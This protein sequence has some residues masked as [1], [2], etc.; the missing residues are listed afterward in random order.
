MY[1]IFFFFLVKLKS[2]IFTLFSEFISEFEN[3][4][5]FVN[6]IK[7][8]M[9]FVFVNCCQNWHPDRLVVCIL[10]K[11]AFS[12]DFLKNFCEFMDTLFMQKFKCMIK[13][14]STKNFIFLKNQ[15][16]YYTDKKYNNIYIVEY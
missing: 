9:Q 3:N 7:F 6:I 15:F 16:E 4:S 10:K 8:S 11:T 14:Y 2:K 12:V 1:L 5:F 13:L